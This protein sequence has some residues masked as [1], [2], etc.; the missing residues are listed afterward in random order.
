MS[1]A[2]RHEDAV[3]RVLGPVMQ[4]IGEANGIIFKRYCRCK[5]DRAVVATIELTAG[6]PNEIARMG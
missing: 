1:I 2:F 6:L 4:P 3:G 5:I